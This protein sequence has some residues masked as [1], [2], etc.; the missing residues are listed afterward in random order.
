MVVSRVTERS[1][2]NLSGDIDLLKAPNLTVWLGVLKFIF[3]FKIL[4][5]LWTVK[6]WTTAMYLST[7]S[8]RVEYRDPICNNISQ[9]TGFNSIWISKPSL[10]KFWSNPKVIQV[11]VTTQIPNS[12][13]FCWLDTMNNSFPQ[14]NHFATVSF[15]WSLPA[16]SRTT[17]KIKMHPSLKCF[18]FAKLA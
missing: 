10:Q 1:F 14:R 8:A 15:R 2:T 13:T 17:S 7:D 12:K 11:F 9:N 16:L 18:H 3:H 6:G 4:E 5:D